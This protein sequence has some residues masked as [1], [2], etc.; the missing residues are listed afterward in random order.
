MLAV[1]PPKPKHPNED[2]RECRILRTVFPVNEYPDSIV[3]HRESPDFVI[4]DGDVTLGVEITQSFRSQASARLMNIPDYFNDIVERQK[5]RGEADKEDL[6]PA[7]RGDEQVILQH[8]EPGERPDRFARAIRAKTAKNYDLTGF[9]QSDL[10]VL[11]G[12]D[13]PFEPNHYDLGAILTEEVQDALLRC[14]FD[15]VHLV[16]RTDGTQANP[17]GQYVSLPCQTLV[18]WSHWYGFRWAASHAP[19]PITLLH[20]YEMLAGYLSH[21]TSRSHMVV[22]N[23]E[24]AIRYGTLALPARDGF[25]PIRLTD[26]K[27]RSVLARARKS[28]RARDLNTLV[29]LSNT[30]PGLP[31]SLAVKAQHQ[32]QDSRGGHGKNGL[33]V[34]FAQKTAPEV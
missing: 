23:G 28:V 13:H 22:V 29:A 14:P 8:V 4:Y 11:D 3:Q 31:G 2:E 20:S 1:V 25:E 10:I 21:F 16:V 9:D 15:E 5:Y 34:H 33:P 18:L 19:F 26:G 12:L 30:A 32:I 27:K 7:T 6:L 24:P 17:G